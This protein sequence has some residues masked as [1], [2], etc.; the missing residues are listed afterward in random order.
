MREPLKLT[1]VHDPLLAILLLL[2]LLGIG[3][4]LAQRAKPAPPPPGTTRALAA[5]EL[6]LGLGQKLEAVRPGLSKT[7]LEAGRQQLRAPWDRA[8]WAVDA[9]EAG[10]AAL[11]DRLRAPLPQGEAGLAF[12]RAWSAA[13]EDGELPAVL[14]AP[15][16]GTR[17]GALLENR[18]RARQGLA[19][20]P[21]PEPNFARLALIGAL[22]TLLLL[23]GGA[24]FIY[25]LAT[26]HKPALPQPAWRLDGRGALLVLG[27]WLVGF[28]LLNTGVAL[29]LRDLP[30]GRLWTLPFGYA[31]HAIFGTWLLM[32]VEGLS[33]AELRA[34]VAP[35]GR[36]A[37]ALAWAPAFL[38]LALAVIIAVAILWAPFMK[39]H[40]NPQEEMQ[41]L[42]RG[43][44]GWPL[45][46]ALFLTIAGLAP[47]FEEL[48]FRGF[49]LPWAGQRWG[50]AWGLA[51]SSLLFGFIHLQPMALPILAALGFV[52]GLAA[53]RGGS[54]WTSIAVHGCWNASVFLLARSL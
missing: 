24:T 42:I 30:Q 12:A 18:L 22:V 6:Q 17:A 36:G 50:A 38:G 47:C 5:L 8:A 3:A 44:Q 49:F 25:L 4:T 46:A 20:L 43:A 19:A 39:G 31:L 41:T 9:Q 28:F 1:K 34:R 11:A 48:L 53:R 15:L 40:A 2:A 51:A 54:V 14:P 16:K 26:A 32:R 37:R 52:L 45:Q 35:S 23:A 10:D 7:F 27:G 33:F 21:L 29:A 13:Y